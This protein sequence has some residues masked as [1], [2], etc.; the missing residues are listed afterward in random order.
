MRSP[1]TTDLAGGRA[2]EPADQ[3]EQGGLAGAGRP[4]QRDEVALRDVE[5]E[6][7]QHLD[8]LLA[9]HVGLLHVADLDHRFT[10]RLTPARRPHLHP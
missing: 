4:H 1:P 6:P 3:V 9:A 7:V 10:H 5:R 8:R 2:V